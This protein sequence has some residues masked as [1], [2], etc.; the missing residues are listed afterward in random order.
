MGDRSREEVVSSKSALPTGSFDLHFYNT[1]F[2]TKDVDIDAD[3]FT[4]C[5][6]NP[7]VND[8]TYFK[9]VSLRDFRLHDNSFCIDKGTQNTPFSISTDQL[10]SPRDVTPDLGAFEYKP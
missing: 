7:A 1:L 9:D 8:T 4:D 6:F 5:Y 3:K 10:G 2:R